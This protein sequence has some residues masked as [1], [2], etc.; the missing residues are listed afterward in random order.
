VVYT[1]FLTYKLHSDARPRYGVL[2]S[3]EYTI[4]LEKLV[5]LELMNE[6][7][8]SPDNASELASAILSP[9]SRR[10]VERLKFIRELIDK[11]LKK[12]SSLRIEEL[13]ELGLVQSLNEL[14]FLPPIFDPGKIIGIG[15]NY[16]EYRLMLKYPKP[17]VPLFFFKPASTL[18]GHRDYVIIPR[19]GRWP[20]TMSRIVFH[21]YELALVIGRRA[22]FID[23]SKALDYVF[24][25][26]IFSDITAHDIEMIQPGYVLYQQRAKAFDTFS[27]MGPWIVTVDEFTRNG[28]DPHN[29]KILRRRNSVVEGE[30]N[31]RNMT[32]KIGEILEF[33]SEIMTLEPGDIISLGSPPAGPLEGLQ[34]GD[35]IEAEIEYIGTLVNYVK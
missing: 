17:E 9:S 10:V 28:I 35:T 27:P 7:D 29:L 20:G 21:E 6:Y 1:R 2:F 34:P 19:G 12:Y 26:T 32:F 25:F 16:E 15:Q 24:G 3:S 4:D 30:S 13:K 8:I 14:K 33:L 31:T 5:T 22:R 11:G 18:I 23:K